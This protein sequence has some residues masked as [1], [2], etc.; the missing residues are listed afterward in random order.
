MRKSFRLFTS[1]EETVELINNNVFDEKNELI[2]QNTS[3]TP[4]PLH[5]QGSADNFPEMKDFELKSRLTG[6]TSIGSQGL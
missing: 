6:S 3:L 5:A 2:K 1:E 4:A